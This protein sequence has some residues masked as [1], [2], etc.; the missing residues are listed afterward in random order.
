MPEMEVYG[1]AVIPII[2]G[3]I[4]AAKAGGL[5]KRF[6]PILAL[7]LG[8]AAGVIYLNPDSIKGGLL[9]GIAAGLA[10]VGLYS[11]TSNVMKRR[12]QNGE[13]EEGDE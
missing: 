6:A 1:I 12:Q 5:P 7:I 9:Q 13:E 3:L 10:S 11:G 4:E 2:V 8:V